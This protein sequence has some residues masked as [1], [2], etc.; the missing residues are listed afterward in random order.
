MFPSHATTQIHRTWQVCVASE[1]PCLRHSGPSTGCHAHSRPQNRQ[2]HPTLGRRYWTLREGK[3][4]VME[5]QERRQGKQASWRSRVGHKV[6]D[7]W[8]RPSRPGG[9]RKP[10]PVSYSLVGCGPS[11]APGTGQF[12]Q[13]TPE[14][15]SVWYV[16]FEDHR[17]LGEKTG[18]CSKHVEWW[19]RGGL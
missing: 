5:T 11:R 9:R 7:S 13:T 8:E 17:G 4:L 2:R 10:S 1:P 15:I 3:V 16:C 6:V 12:Q 19:S 18:W 14:K